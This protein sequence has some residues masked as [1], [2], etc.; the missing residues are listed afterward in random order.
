MLK[1]TLLFFAINMLSCS[2][3]NTEPTDSRVE[4]DT[5]VI[6]NKEKKNK[7]H[8][9]FLHQRNIG[10]ALLRQGKIRQ[11]IVADSLAMILAEKVESYTTCL[12]TV[13]SLESKYNLEKNKVQA[14]QICHKG[15]SIAEKNKD[16]VAMANLYSS[17]GLSYFF[18][19]DIEKALPAHLKSLELSKLSKYSF[20]ISSALV[21]VGSDYVALSQ[22]EKAIPYYLECKKYADTLKG[23][24][25]ESQ[26]YNSVAAAWWLS[27]QYDSAY[28]YSDLACRIA[29]KLQNKRGMA[30]SLSSMARIKFLQGNINE[31][32]LLSEKAFAFCIESSFTAQLPDLYLLIRDINKT[33]GNYSK[34]LDAFEKYVKIKDSI[35]DESTGRIIQYKEYAH[36]LEKKNAENRF[37]AQGNVLRDLKISRNLYMSAIFIFVLLLIIIIGVLLFRQSKIKAMHLHVLTEQKMLRAQMNPHF[38]FNALNSIQNLIMRSQNLQAETY[39]SRFS[40]LLRNILETGTDDGLPINQEVEILKG[41][42]E[43]EAL[44]FDG[45]FNYSVQIEPELAEKNSRIP[46]LMVQPFVENAIWHGLLPKEDNRN[47]DIVFKFTDNSKCICIIDDNGIGRIESGKQSREGKKKQQAL[48]FTTHRLALMNKAYG[49]NCKMT[50]IDKYDDAN[51]N[52]GTTVKIELPFI[53]K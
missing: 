41:Y 13:R 53:S 28:V 32:H 44:R 23:T 8:N 19:N 36:T 20:G 4:E 35:T 21:D 9:E 11:A 40:K 6:T 37:L 48:A 3:G 15:I 52:C 29:E 50:I 51:R 25:Y 33:T 47:V 2:I 34:A 27:K 30:S 1:W 17:I 42:L 43:I 38:I 14:I 24:I 10:E 49:T 12:E 45:A 22:F 18:V 7:L 46:A 5:M 16:T 39:L 26:I 31:A